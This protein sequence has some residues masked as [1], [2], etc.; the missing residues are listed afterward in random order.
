MVRDITP[1]EAAEMI[2]NTKILFIDCWA[3]W[4]GPCLALAP[5]MEEL[6]EKYKDNRDIEF[7]KINTQNH[8]QFAMDNNI[9]AIPC[10][11][12]FK[13]GKPASFKIEDARSKNQVTTDR[14]IGLRPIEHYEAVIDQLL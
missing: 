4:C 10:V 9:V 1:D 5:T 12:V 8:R 11:L 3:P 13:D 7:V 2:E 14:L 6:E